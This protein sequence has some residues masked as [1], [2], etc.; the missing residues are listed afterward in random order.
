MSA[1]GD[2]WGARRRARF[3]RRQERERLGVLHPPPRLGGKA[4]RAQRQEE[5]AARAELHGG[6]RTLAALVGARRS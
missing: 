6:E 5:A 1:P 4:R 3:K 2:D